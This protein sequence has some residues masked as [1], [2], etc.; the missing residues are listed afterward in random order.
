MRLIAR[1]L[2]CSIR[3]R[4]ALAKRSFERCPCSL[5]VARVPYIGTMA[6][7]AHMILWIQLEVTALLPQS[8][9]RERKGPLVVQRILFYVLRD[10]LVDCVRVNLKVTIV[11]HL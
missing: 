3:R 9:S 4:S 7:F 10:D 8:G 1:A 6:T 11:G 2:Q 5:H